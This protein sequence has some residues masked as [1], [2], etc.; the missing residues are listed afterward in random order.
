MSQPGSAERET[1]AHKADQLQTAYNVKQEEFAFREKQ[2]QSE[3]DVRLKQAQQRLQDAVG[4]GAQGRQLGQ[5][6]DGDV[7]GLQGRNLVGA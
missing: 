4:L 7:A 1:M 5:L 6:E 2:L 3:Y